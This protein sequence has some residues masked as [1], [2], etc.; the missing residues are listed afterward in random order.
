VLDTDPIPAAC[1]ATG[2]ADWVRLAQTPGLGRA[3]MRQLLDRFGAPCQ[4]FAAGHAALAACLPDA[5]AR[6]LCQPMPQ[7]IARQ[8]DGAMEWLAQPS[9]HLLTLHD[10]RY[11][12]TL[13]HIPDPPPLLYLR[14]R[15][16]LLAG[17]ALAI[18]GSRNATLQGCA[19]AEVFAEALSG[20]GLTIVS[21]LA[22][23][24][25]AAAHAGGLR[26]IGSTVAVIGTGADLVYPARNRDLAQRIAAEGCIVSEYSLGTPAVAANFP[27]R[28]RVISGLAA[29]VL[30]VEAAD[31]SGS[32]ITAHLAAEQGREVF[33]IPGSIHAPLAKGCHK[34][35]Q[36]GAK[37]VESA[38]DVL[39]ELRLSPLA[40]ARAPPAPC[41]PA[42]APSAA[43]LLAALG[44]DPADADTLAMRTASAPGALLGELLALELEGRVE[45]LPGGLFQRVNR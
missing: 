9:H 17:P 13:A 43:A 8:V 21:G 12:A 42:V 34:L 10:P 18:V 7:P 14:G 44:Q 32:L 36:E 37:L 45:R 23:G 26:A 40:A 1:P 15:P 11:P 4:I 28:N 22:L 27:R 33:A 24:I 6:A 31:R 41:R 38:A 30:V 25:D 29:G 19:N 5:L 39:G 3:T 20:A 16:E 2:L 35:I